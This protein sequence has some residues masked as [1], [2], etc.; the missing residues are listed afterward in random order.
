[1]TGA[2]Q[3]VVLEFNQASHQPHVW[4]SEV[5]DDLKQART[6]RDLARAATARTGRREEHGVY[7]LTEVEDHDN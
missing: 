5:Y 2:R 7:E 4:G 6:Y 1:M 3:F